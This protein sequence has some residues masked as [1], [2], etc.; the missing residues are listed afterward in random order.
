MAAL[1]EF[2]GSESLPVIAKVYFWKAYIIHF[3]QDFSCCLFSWVLSVV[4][5][6]LKS[7]SQK[8]FLSNR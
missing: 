2:D 5:Q 6:H 7:L 3:G 4:L 1:M 8:N